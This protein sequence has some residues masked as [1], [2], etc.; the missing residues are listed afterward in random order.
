MCKENLFAITE[1]ALAVWI[2]EEF[3]AV[4]DM[5]SVDRPSLCSLLLGIPTGRGYNLQRT[6][7]IAHHEKNCININVGYIIKC[8]EN[9]K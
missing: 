8:D 2:P 4:D 7:N 3:H 9:T 1:L 6:R 5:E